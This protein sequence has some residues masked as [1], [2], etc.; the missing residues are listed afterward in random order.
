MPSLQTIFS[1]IATYKYLILFPAS[2]LE[3][4]IISIIGGF[5]AAQ[6]ILNIVV[7]FW[8]VV[9]GDIVGD[10]IYYS[11]GRYGT[12][13]AILRWGKYIGIAEP[14]LDH[15]EKQFKHSGRK[16]LLLGK[17]THAAGSVVLVSAGAAS[18]PIIDFILLNLLGTMP[19]SL[20]FVIIGFYFGEAYMQISTY[21]DYFSGASAALV[22]LAL[23]GFYFFY[24]YKK[25]NLPR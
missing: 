6:K 5:L 4:P 9:A 18:V 23:L 8:V 19:K 11:V 2:V 24:L 10:L 15:L 20:L 14:E 25:K 12:K 1:L 17:L 3:G 16:I 7:V 13:K 21:F 22:G